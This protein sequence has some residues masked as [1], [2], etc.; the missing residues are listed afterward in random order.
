MSIEFNKQMKYDLKKYE[1]DDVEQALTEFEDF[2][3]HTLTK[4]ELPS[5]Q[6]FKIARHALHYHL[7]LQI[8]AQQEDL[9]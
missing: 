4:D 3:H 6:S 8:L 1:I 9:K 5:S 7:L 2:T